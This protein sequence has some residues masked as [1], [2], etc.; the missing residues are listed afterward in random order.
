MF[1]SRIPAPS[2]GTLNRR[3]TLAARSPLVLAST[4]ALVLS[5]AV[6]HATN[7]YFTHGFG[8]ANKGLAGAG[9]ALPQDA[10]SAAVNP[11]G[12]AFV[13]HRYDA[14]LALF[15]PNRQVTVRGNPSG[16]PGTFG[17]TPG[18]VESDERLFE[19]PHFGANWE[20]GEK[21]S[22]GLTL[23]AQGGMNT[24]YPAAVFFGSSPTG[25]DLAQLFLAP[26]WSRKVGDRHAFGVTP[27]LAF[28]RFEMRGVEAFAAFS[29]RPDAVSNN[30]HD[31]SF[32]YGLKLGYLGRLTPRF[33]VGVAWQSEIR[34][35]EFDDYAGLFAGD[36]DF[37][38]PAAATVGIAYQLTP[39]V[40]L[41][42]DVQEIYYSD[43]PA[44]GLPMFPNLLQAP[45]GDAAG[46]GFGW[47]DM[48]VFKLGVLWRAS[49]TWTLRFGASTG[50][51]PIPESEVFFNILAPGVM[52]EHV[53][54]GFSR[55]MGDGRSLN[56]AVMHAFSSR[57]RGANLLEAPG[58]QEIEL[59]MDQWELE[60][61]WSWGF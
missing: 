56:V 16:F 4:L 28:Q 37:D 14:G 44:V 18:T 2:R 34:M 31:E 57:V 47:E 19:I 5:A 42:A 46:P 20:L 59:Q 1:A 25:V 13:G 17:L 52:E 45:L 49:D 36:G 3:R 33:S 55:S 58:L 39:A 24:T 43:V 6:A 29:Q 7:G 54:A 60:V 50:E 21:T 32:G 22:L 10:L 40:T 48:T 61:S 12:M 26:T 8:T 53:T 41:A 30:G 23:Y 9:A 27:V 38:I 15:N 11:A 51:Q 35:S